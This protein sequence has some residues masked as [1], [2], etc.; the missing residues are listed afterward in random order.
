VQQKKAPI[1]IPRK[2]W[3]FRLRKVG[4]IFF[5]F[6]R[7][8]FF[9]R[10]GKIFMLLRG[11]LLTYLHSTTSTSLFSMS[12][13]YLNN[14]NEERTKSQLYKLLSTYLKRIPRMSCR[15]QAHCSFL[16]KA[17]TTV[18]EME[19]V[20]SRNCRSSRF[21]T[22]MYILQRGRRNVG[23]LRKMKSHCQVCSAQ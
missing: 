15:I 17:Q 11:F 22:Q 4:K 19:A 18:T 3:L 14:H 7:K 9:P 10:E 6:L 16:K 12:D 8:C 5:H 2:V 13:K 1:T 23:H 21:A 20:R